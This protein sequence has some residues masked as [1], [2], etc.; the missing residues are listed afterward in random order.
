MRADICR[1]TSGTDPGREKK[2]RDSLNIRN[3]DVRNTLF[4]Q[5]KMCGKRT[6]IVETLEKNTSFYLLEKMG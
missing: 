6:Y 3:A 2:E 4:S 5:E 1:N